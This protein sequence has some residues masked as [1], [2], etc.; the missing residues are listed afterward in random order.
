[1]RAIGCA[2][3]GWLSPLS[4]W[5]KWRTV[6]ICRYCTAVSALGFVLVDAGEEL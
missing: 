3:V 5:C 2:S 1:M 6:Y 4:G